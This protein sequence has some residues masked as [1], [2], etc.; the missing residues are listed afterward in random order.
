[1]MASSIL[2]CLSSQTQAEE[3]ARRF[4]RRARRPEANR[5]AENI[6]SAAAAADDD[7]GSGDDGGDED[8]DPCGFLRN[9]LLRVPQILR[10]GGQRD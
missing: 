4:P 1:M 9:S 3:T 7:G 10:A 8:E 2:I 6:E 5:S